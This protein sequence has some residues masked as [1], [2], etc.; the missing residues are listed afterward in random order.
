MGYHQV[1][2]DPNN[3]FKTAF[4]T[5]KGFYSYNVMPCG[6]CNAPATFQRLMEKILGTLVGCGVLVYLDDVL[7]YASTTEKLLDK[8]SQVLQLLAAAGRKFKGSKCFLFT[9]TV[10]YLEHIVSKDGIH[11]ELAKLEKI[12]KL[13]QNSEKGT[14]LASFQGFCN[15]YRDLVPDFANV[16]D[17]LYKVFRSEYIEWTPT[18]AASFEALKRLLIE[19]RIVIL[20]DPEKEFILETDPSRVALGGVLKQRFEDTNLEHPVGFFSRALTG[21]ERNYV[22]YKLEMYA[23]VRA[24]QHFRMFLLGKISCS[25]LTKRRF[26]TCY[27]EI[28]LRLLGLGAESCGFRSTPFALS[29]SAEKSTSSQTSCRAYRLLRLKKP[30]KL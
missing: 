27:A 6:L 24:T 30:V 23:V 12:L 7:T 15:Y 20:P 4:L 28:Y 18:L 29:T 1:E 26:A 16:S 25:E 2:V 3:R 5:H 9:E 14:K 13:P 11:P 17:P 22:A 8:L 19:F 21:S 10:H